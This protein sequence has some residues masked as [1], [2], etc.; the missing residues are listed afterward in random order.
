MYDFIIR[1]IRNRLPAAA[2]LA[3]HKV[4]LEC[5]HSHAKLNAPYFFY[6]FLDTHS[7]EDERNEP[8]DVDKFTRLSKLKGLCCHFRLNHPVSDHK[9]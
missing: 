5:S 9:I 2:S 3:G 7:F 8:R 6:E 4:I 1:I